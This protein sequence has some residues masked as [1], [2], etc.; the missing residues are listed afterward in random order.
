MACRRLA[1]FLLFFLS[2]SP[3]SAQLRSGSLKV[4]ITFPDGHACNIIVRVQLMSGGSTSPL[5]EGYTNNAGMTEFNNLEIGNYHLIVSGEGIEE[6]DS[7][8]FEVSNRRGSQYQYVVVKRVK[9]ANEPNNA[10]G[11]P[12]VSAV[13]LNIPENAAKEFDK[14]TELM[15]KENWRKAIERFSKALAI[16]PKYAAAY[17]N[18]GVVYAR[19]GERSQEREVLKKAIEVNDHF[20]PAIVNLA[21][22]AIAD[23]DMPQAETLL[24]RAIS[25]DPKNTLTLILLANVELLDHHYEMAIANCRKAHSL[26]QDPHALAHYIAGRALEHQNRPLDAAAEFQIFLQEEPTGERA[27]SVRRELAILQNHIRRD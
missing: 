21:R 6:A 27:E 5:A 17:N 24:E 8:P 12:T 18:L 16:Y 2:L 14:G 19:M 7:G 20:A 15:A 26:A 1:A 4:R 22:M 11:P 10:P 9:D 3:A 23:R 25:A 13:D